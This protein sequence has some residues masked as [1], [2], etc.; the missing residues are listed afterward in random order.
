M[1]NK[2]LN[3]K[4]RE[5]F[6]KNSCNRLRSAGVIPGVI[7]SHGKTESIAIPTKEFYSIFKSHISESVLFKVLVDGKDGDQMAFVKDFQRNPATGELVHID[8]FKVTKG[9]KIH[10]TVPLKITGTPKGTKIG[11]LLEISKHEIEVECLPMELPE[12]IEVDVTDLDLNEY[13]HAKDIKLADGV[14]LKS[15][16]E[17]VIA[18]VHTPR[19]VA[20]E[21]TEAPVAEGE[22]DAAATTEKT[23]E[24]ESK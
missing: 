7:Y 13:I 10:T 19:A 6:K 11:G 23:D 24:K 1:Q 3:V 12:T 22:A 15:N 8:L 20:A 14:K 18:S 5:Q 21:E 16:P 9:E 4:S 17:T 2:V